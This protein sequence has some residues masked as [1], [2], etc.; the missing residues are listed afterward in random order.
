MAAL[1]LLSFTWFAGQGLL[2][3]YDQRKHFPRGGLHGSYANTA[4]L[5]ESCD[6][7]REYTPPASLILSSPDI[8]MVNYL[9]QRPVMAT[10]RNIPSAAADIAE[11]YQRL[12]DLNG[13][14]EPR[15][16][17]YSASR[18]IDRNFARLSDEA[19]IDLGRKYGAR[20]L[21]V[22]NRRGCRLPRLFQNAYWSV[23]LLD[24]PEDA[25][26][27]ASTISAPETTRPE[28][29]GEN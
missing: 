17:G 11:W 25:D 6:W 3:G 15:S 18:E 7:I 8:D 21:L 1:L 20:Y 12:V 14:V 4:A 22:Q 23:Y 5:H 19:Y 10:F 2:K 27:F 16:R 26:G 13:G 28:G 29:T 9:C 24:G